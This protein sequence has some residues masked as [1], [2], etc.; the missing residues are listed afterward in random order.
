VLLENTVPGAMV[1][2]RASENASV[3]HRPRLV[4]TLR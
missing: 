2:I 1:K 4:I 3:E